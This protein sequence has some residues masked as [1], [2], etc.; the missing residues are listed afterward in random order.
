MAFIFFLQIVEDTRV[1]E[2]TRQLEA[3]QAEIERQRVDMEWHITQLVFEQRSVE[4][5][6][7]RADAVQERLDRAEEQVGFT[8]TRF[9]G[10]TS[11]EKA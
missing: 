7:Q 10:T 1:Q 2:L 11:V 9:M 6:R 3:A 8:L 4:E 5:H